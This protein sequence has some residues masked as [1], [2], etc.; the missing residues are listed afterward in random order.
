M[1]MNDNPGSSSEVDN[2]AGIDLDRHGE[3]VFKLRED[4]PP[5]GLWSWCGALHGPNDR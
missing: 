1:M 3:R 2:G 5:P 4:L